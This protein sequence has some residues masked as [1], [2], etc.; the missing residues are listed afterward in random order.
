MLN[1]LFNLASDDLMFLPSIICNLEAS[2][3]HL[4]NISSIT[5]LDSIKNGSF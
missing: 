3:V 5:T 2:L 1:M 4:L